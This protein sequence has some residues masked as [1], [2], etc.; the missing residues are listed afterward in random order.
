M[1]WTLTRITAPFR[2]ETK[3]KT[4]MKLTF[5]AILILAL[6]AGLALL[7]VDSNTDTPFQ[8][9][10]QTEML[11]TRGAGTCETYRPVYPSSGSCSSSD[12]A[13]S[14]NGSGWSSST[15]SGGGHAVCGEESSSTDCFTSDEYNQ[16]CAEQ[17]DYVGPYCISWFRTGYITRIWTNGV[18][19]L[20]NTSC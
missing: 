4:L 13:T 3:E 18:Y 17:Y 1:Y 7:Q 15:R 16:Q 12:C 2:A 9:L 8:A 5:Y 10:S 19:T 6:I 20:S 11:A 14:W